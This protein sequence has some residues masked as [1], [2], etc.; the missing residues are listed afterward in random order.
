MSAPPPSVPRAAVHLRSADLRDRDSPWHLL[1]DRLDCGI[2]IYDPETRLV[3]CNQE[4]RRQYRPVAEHIVPGLRFGEL[5]RRVV[6]A[7]LVPQASGREAEWIAAR[8]RDFGRS[9]APFERQ[10]VDGRW[11]RISETRLADGGVMS[12]SADITELVEKRRALQQALEAARTA[13]ERLDDAIEALPAGFE[14]WDAE[15]RLVLCNGELR[16]MYPAIADALQPGARFQDLVRANH[17]AGALQ[18]PAAE[19][20]SYIARR[21]EQRGRSAEPADHATGDGRWYRVF[22]RP[23]R[24][25][26]LVGVRLDV[27]ELRNQRVA[28]EQ[29]RADAEAARRR[30]GDAIE[31]L[32]DGF[33]LFD[34]DDRLVLCNARYRA[35]YRESAALIE[36][37]VRFETLLRH[38]LAQG[39]YPQAAG[40]EPG[41]LAARL[42]QHR[43]PKGPFLQQLPGNRW[44]RIDERITRDGGIAGVRSEVT[45]LVRREQQLTELNAELGAARARLEQ[46]SETDALTGIANRRRFDR[47]F[48]EEWSRVVRHGAALG[49]LLVDIDHFKAYNDRHGHQAGDDCLRRV[50]ALLDGCAGR[51]TDVVARYGGEEF[52]LLL[53]H[54]RRD[55]VGAVDAAALDHGAS[56]VARQ[57]TISVGLA[58]AERG[59]AAQGRALLAAADAAL[60][61]AKATGRHRVEGAA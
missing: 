35:L 1:L 53:P 52:A 14:L 7:G 47:R 54:M 51:P 18:V 12:F 44:L 15:D 37:G 29:A 22:H 41:W 19:L 9:D 32:P 4:F 8:E 10:M 17:A 3:T 50:A 56:P 23:T 6:H 27:T 39:Q 38:G 48:T 26:A 20:E 30:L 28:A 34:A 36:P 31:A 46:L 55:E 33:A 5:L 13:H 40:D 11:R 25:G 57:V 58:W 24:H 42:Q 43:E 49:L 16:R 60:Y 45:E 59:D 21:R 2:A 61:R